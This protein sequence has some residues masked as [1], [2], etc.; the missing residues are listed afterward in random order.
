MLELNKIYNMDCIDG[1][2]L[3][4]D[5]SIDLIVTDPPYLI[6]YQT[7][8]RKRNNEKISAKIIGDTD[9]ELIEKYIQDCNRIMKEN[10]ALYMFCSF[11][12][13]E[14][15]KLELQKYFKIKNMIIWEKNN[16]T[17]GDLEAQFQKKYEIMFLVNKGRKKFN[18][19]RITDVWKFS[20]VTEKQRIHSNQK[21]IE[22]INQCIVKHSNENEVV[23]DGFMG[24]GTT[25]VSAYNL[26]R[27]FIGF[28]LDKEYFDIA[29][30]RIKQEVDQI[31]LF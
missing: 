13:I 6:D 16:G 11:D 5:N 30:L 8:R 4:E 21:P 3:I 9:F 24:S 2:K 14:L 7:N 12:K 23:F 18:G 26:N 28:E 10:T 1:M 17:V 22:L 25:A 20:K 19:K 29:S 15:F 27:K 31:K